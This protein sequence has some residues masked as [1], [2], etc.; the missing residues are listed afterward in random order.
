MWSQGNAH[1][2]REPVVFGCSRY[3]GG[4]GRRIGWR[5]VAAAATTPILVF[6]TRMLAP[7][8]RLVHG[9]AAER[10][11]LICVYFQ[12]SAAREPVDQPSLEMRQTA[13]RT[14]IFHNQ[15]VHE[16]RGIAGADV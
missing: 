5:R 13:D 2:R 7:S 11:L 12:V 10:K 1:E 6:G 8:H 3:G 15:I 9:L 4:H 16:P 14:V